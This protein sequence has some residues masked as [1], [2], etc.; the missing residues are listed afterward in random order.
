MQL[1]WNSLVVIGPA[2]D[3]GYY[4]LGCREQVHAQLFEDIEWSTP[5]VLA[6]TLS[7]AAAIGLSVAPLDTLPRLQDIDTAEDLRSWLLNAESDA[8]T[9][10][11]LAEALLC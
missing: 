5:N 11:S 2:V 3:G 8:S 9:V 1:V 4:L 10:R 7:R 6:A